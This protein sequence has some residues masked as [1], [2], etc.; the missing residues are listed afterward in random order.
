MSGALRGLPSNVDLA[1]VE[2][3]AGDTYDLTLR[4]LGALDQMGE[5][6]AHC[7]GRAVVDDI[8]NQHGLMG[9]V[10]RVGA[11]SAPTGIDNE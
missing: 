8:L 10:P 11:G 2:S 1:G 3:R 9:S 4:L 7:L 5:Q 6:L